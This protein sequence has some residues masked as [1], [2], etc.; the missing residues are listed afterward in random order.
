MKRFVF[1]FCKHVF[2]CLVY[3]MAWLQW[4]HPHLSL[5]QELHQGLCHTPTARWEKNRRAHTYCSSQPLLV[6]WK[7]PVS[8]LKNSSFYEIYT[9]IKYIK[10]LQILSTTGPLPSPPAVEPTS[11]QRKTTGPCNLIFSSIFS[12]PAFLI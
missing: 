4:I 5:C 1:L 7:N 2:L 10:H 8:S 9:G 6:C 11:Y 12:P 3:N